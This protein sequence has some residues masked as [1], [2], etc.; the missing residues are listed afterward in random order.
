MMVILCM[1]SWD[2]CLPG[3]Y[4]AGMTLVF[5]RTGALLLNHDGKER[6]KMI[7]IVVVMIMLA[8]MIVI[9]MMNLN[10]LHMMIL[11]NC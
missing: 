10:H 5:V 3:R 11:S 1:D 4:A 2:H 9:V 6:Y 8:M 7:M